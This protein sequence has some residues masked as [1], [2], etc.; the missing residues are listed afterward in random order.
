MGLA[1]GSVVL[2][3]LVV[4]GLGKD[5]FVEAPFWAFELEAWGEFADVVGGDKSGGSGGENGGD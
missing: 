4:L 1:D 2:F 5:G 3:E